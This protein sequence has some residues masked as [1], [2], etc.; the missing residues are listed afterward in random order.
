MVTISQSFPHGPPPPRPK[1]KMPGSD[2]GNARCLW[3]FASLFLPCFH[4]PGLP[5]F[6]LPVEYLS[7]LN[8][9]QPHLYMPP[10]LPTSHHRAPHSD[11]FAPSVARQPRECPTLCKCS[12][13]AGSTIKE[14]EA[15]HWE[16]EK[17]ADVPKKSVAPAVESF[18]QWGG[19]PHH[20]TSAGLQPVEETM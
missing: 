4:F 17:R 16:E 18:C 13:Q 14:W 3:Y 20:S 8:A 10:C 15:S 11:V 2:F 7:S 19:A 9:W 12:G 6:Y 1:S 5:L